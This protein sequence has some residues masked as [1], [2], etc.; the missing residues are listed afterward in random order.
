VPIIA[1]PTSNP[2]RTMYQNQYNNQTTYP[3]NSYSN[4]YQSGYSTQ[5]SGNDYGSQT[6]SYGNKSSYGS[7][8][9]RRG[10]Y[11]K[12]REN[13]RDFGG[14]GYFRESGKSVCTPIQ[15][16]QIKM[17]PY[18]WKTNPN[19]I[20]IPRSK[21]KLL[22]ITNKKTQYEVEIDKIAKEYNTPENDITFFEEV[23]HA[24]KSKKHRY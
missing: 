17:A 16:M 19:F 11:S 6:S 1:K 24:R 13:G 15:R 20:P 22:Q 5:T 9:Q 21:N 18:T 14:F 23:Q 10:G 12:S 8:N 3:T 7:Y 4:P 2:F